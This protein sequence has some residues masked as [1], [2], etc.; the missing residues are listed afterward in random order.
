MADDIS[1]KRE[2]VKGA[3]KG[4][5]WRDKVDAMPEDQVIAVYLRLQS[6]KKI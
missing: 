6:Q 5:Q 2:A 3:Y 1:K 4:K